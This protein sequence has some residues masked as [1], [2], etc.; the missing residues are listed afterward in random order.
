MKKYFI[1][2]L[3]VALIYTGIVSATEIESLNFPNKT[4]ISQVGIWQRGCKVVMS[5]AP[6]VVPEESLK[7]SVCF[8]VESPGNNE[9]NAQAFFAKTMKIVKGQCYRLSFHVM[10]PQEVHFK[11][12][13]LQN[14]PTWERLASDSCRTVTTSPNRWQSVK[15]DFTANRDLSGSVRI[16]CFTFGKLPKDTE[17]YISDIRFE[18]VPFEE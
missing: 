18:S 1:P 17:I 3:A 13:V 7:G 15:I 12:I 2:T 6:G 10:S 8:F 16:P 5:Y 11:A 4:S 14:F 9:E